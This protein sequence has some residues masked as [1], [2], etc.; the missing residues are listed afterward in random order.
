VTRRLIEARITRFTHESSN[1]DLTFSTVSLTAKF[2]GVI[3]GL[4]I[5]TKV[6]ALE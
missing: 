5:A 6:D 3:Y 4:S 1:K 2:K